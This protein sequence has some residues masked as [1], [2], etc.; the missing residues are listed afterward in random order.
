MSTV[1]RIQ[2]ASPPDDAENVVRDAFAEIERLESTRLSG[3]I[4]ENILRELGVVAD[5]IG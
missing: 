5:H 2:V 1:F 3:P 4:A